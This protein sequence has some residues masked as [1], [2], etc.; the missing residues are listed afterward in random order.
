MIAAVLVPF[1]LFCYLLES[2][3][4]PKFSSFNLR[5]AF[6]AEFEKIPLPCIGDRFILKT[7]LY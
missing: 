6:I 1:W 2:E 7:G 4:I 3:L 5:S